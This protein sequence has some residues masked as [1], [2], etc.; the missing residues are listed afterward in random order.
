MCANSECPAFSAISDG[1]KSQA[2][3]TSQAMSP[4]GQ[5]NNWTASFVSPKRAA[6]CKR[7][8]NSSWPAQKK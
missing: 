5:S 7:V 2:F 4:P 1:V 8:G 3:R 6:K